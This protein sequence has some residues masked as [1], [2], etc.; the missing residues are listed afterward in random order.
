MLAWNRNDIDLTLRPPAAYGKVPEPT[1]HPQAYT[2]F[3]PSSKKKC[4]EATEEMF[5]PPLHVEVFMMN[6]FISPPLLFLF[7]VIVACL[8]VSIVTHSVR[9]VKDT[10]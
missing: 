3:V 8:A 5:L 9:V 1:S 2:L 4:K 10:Y 6:R 7:R